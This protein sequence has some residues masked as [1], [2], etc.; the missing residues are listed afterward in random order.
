MVTHRMFNL[1][2]LLPH[3][4][5][6]WVYSTPLRY[7]VVVRHPV[8]LVVVTAVLVTIFARIG[9]TTDTRIPDLRVT[10][11]P[12]NPLAMERIHFSPDEKITCKEIFNAFFVGIRYNISIAWMLSSRFCVLYLT[13]FSSC[14]LFQFAAFPL[15]RSK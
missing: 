9:G 13:L 1:Q 14:I 8:S 6:K 15:V 2:Q 12:I 4:L 5:R 11:T 3:R 7:Q 10:I